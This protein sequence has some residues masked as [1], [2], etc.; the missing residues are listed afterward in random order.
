MAQGNYVL[1]NHHVI[2]DAKKIKVHLN[3]EKERY[4]AQVIADD[5]TGDMALLKI[6]LPA[7]KTLRP[8]PLADTGLKIGEDVLRH[9][10]SRS[11]EPECHL[12]P[13]Q[14]RRQQLPDPA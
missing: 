12:D 13:D 6:D 8:I 3:G 1:T 5:E 9:G 14:R 10:L 7:G 2:E 11:A 4:P